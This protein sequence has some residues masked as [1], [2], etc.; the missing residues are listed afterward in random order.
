MLV[1]CGSQEE[2]SSRK[3]NQI[4]ADVIQKLQQSKIKEATLFLPELNIEGSDIARRIEQIIIQAEYSCYQSDALKTD[5]KK[6]S[7]ALKRITLFIGDRS[8]LATARQALITGQAIASGV[9]LAR[10]LGDL[11]GNICT[12]SYLADQAKELARDFKMK[13]KILNEKAMEKL[14]MGALL[15]VSRGSRQEA[16][17]I[18]LEHKGG[19]DKGCPDSSRR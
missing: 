11:P 12:P 9:N 4:T 8:S 1:G 13:A 19:A 5:K 6:N 3:L 18:I 17:L 7:K 15:S 14:S 2:F 10:Q 16:R